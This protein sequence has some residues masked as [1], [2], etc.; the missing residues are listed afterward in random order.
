[1]PRDDATILDILQAAYRAR[2][3]LG[4][5][6]RDGFLGDAKTQSSVLHQLLVLGEAVKRLSDEFRTRH[7]VIPW[8]RIAGLRNVLIHQYNNVDLV[9]VWKTVAVDL[10][11]L[12]AQLE[13]LAPRPPDPG[14]RNKE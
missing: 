4:D 9:A 8:T 13:P 14:P 11:D 10:P 3:F 7:S 5:L 2:A 12:I 1:M 6:D